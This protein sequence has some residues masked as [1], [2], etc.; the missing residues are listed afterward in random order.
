MTLNRLYNEIAFRVRAAD[1]PLEI[2]ALMRELS[3]EGEHRASTMSRVELENAMSQRG[4][5]AANG[6]LQ[7]QV[8]TVTVQ[9]GSQGF[10]DFQKAARRALRWK[11]APMDSM[12][13]IEA[14]SLSGDRVPYAHLKEALSD[15]GLRFIPGHGYWPHAIYSDPVTRAIS[16]S[17]APRRIASIIGLFRAHGWPLSGKEISTLAGAS[18]LGRK[19][20]EEA[21]H[22]NMFVR[23]I[24]MGMYVPADQTGDLPMSMDVAKRMMEIGNDA[25]ISSDADL[26]AFRIASLMGRKEWAEVKMGRTPGPGK[27]VQKLK[28]TPNREGYRKLLRAA[29]LPVEV[30]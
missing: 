6:L 28:F 11:S 1:D 18:D 14:T 23:P 20:S 26:R 24:G 30:F 2:D 12:D 10:R 17:C 8:D 25:W 19:V 29:R 3:H 16:T 15:V 13:L 4:I 7:L 21:S 9:P 27:R 22:G 5:V